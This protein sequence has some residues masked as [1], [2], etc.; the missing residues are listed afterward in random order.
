MSTVETRLSET[1]WRHIIAR[2]AIIERAADLLV[3]V[4]GPIAV[5]IMGGA[6]AV[7]VIEYVRWLMT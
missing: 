3:D 6:L 5:A 2:L 7:I 1:A 4:F